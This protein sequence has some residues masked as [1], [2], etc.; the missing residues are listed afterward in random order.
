MFG[1]NDEGQK[2]LTMLN[3]RN[4]FQ[5]EF[6]VISCLMV[7]LTWHY[8]CTDVGGDGDWSIQACGSQENGLQSR[9]IDS[10]VPQ[11]HCHVMSCDVM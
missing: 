2:L 6:L 3:D 10:P 11:V 1:V 4:K 5:T 8:V 9:H 7:L